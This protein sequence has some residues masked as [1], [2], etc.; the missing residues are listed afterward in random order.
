MN[1][2]T[3]DVLCTVK[4]D[5]KEKTAGIENH[6]CIGRGSGNVIK[7]L[8]IWIYLMIMIGDIIGHKQ[9]CHTGA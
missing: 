6:Y 2:A 4:F 9:L 5:M 1:R 3:K 8:K 7:K